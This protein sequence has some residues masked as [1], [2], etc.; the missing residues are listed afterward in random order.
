MTPLV[1]GVL[2]VALTLT[3]C[4][5]DE[6]LVEP[7]PSPTP[8]E[9]VEPSPSPSPEPSPEPA[10]PIQWPLTGVAVDDED[11]IAQIP[12]LAIKIEN[13]PQSRPQMGL[14]YAD[15]V[16]EQ[17]VEG[18]ITRYVAVYHS[19]IPE[20][21]L[22]VRSGRPQD[23]AIVAPF[24]G[25]F[26]YSGAQRR[27]IDQI[28]EAGIQ[29]IIMDSGHAGFRRTPDRRAPHNVIGDPEVFLSQARD[30]RQVPAPQIFQ[31]ACEAGLG[32]AA[33][34]GWPVEQVT[35]RMSGAQSSIWNWDE[36]SGTFL[37]S[38]GA[39]PAMSVADVQL[40]AVNVVLLAIRLEYGQGVPETMLSLRYGRAM[41]AAGGRFIEAR[42]EKGY[43]QDPIILLDLE[44]EEILL[45]PGNTWI[46]LVPMHDGGS[47]TFVDADGNDAIGAGDSAD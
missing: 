11:E 12:A 31:Y 35:A 20:A 30:D 25:L 45:D 36:E 23:T 10:C 34:T 1:V 39:N 5:G 41:I 38:N 16:F 37:L 32:T 33:A 47:W 43:H 26:A 29:S 46:H 9:T 7:S 44:G 8:T 18:G 42:W 22:P 2:A 27:F 17:M 14:E 19:N 15:I 28:N 6:P 3:G 4:S 21:V 40:S 24:H 13:S